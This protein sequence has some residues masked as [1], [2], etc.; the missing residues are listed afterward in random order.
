MNPIFGLM[1]D[2]FCSFAQKVIAEE[3]QIQALFCPPL[4]VRVYVCPWIRGEA[5]KLNG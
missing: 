1:Q 4:Y 3:V 5:N 2:I